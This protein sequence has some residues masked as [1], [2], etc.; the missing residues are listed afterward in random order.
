MRKSTLFIS[1]IL[2]TFMIAVLVGVVSNYQNKDKQES[3]APTQEAPVAVE[4]LPTDTA[5]P[6]PTAA[7]GFITPEQA[8]ALASQIL[9]RND[10]LSVETS[11]LNGEQVYLVKFIPG[12]MVYISPSGQILSIVM[13]PTPTAAVVSAPSSSSNSGGNN[14]V[15]TG[16]GNG[17]GGGGGGDDGG[18]GHD[19]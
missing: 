3:V 11:I 1:A 10:L 18:G 15:Q 19:D 9:G 7:Q 13:V 5:L 8:A 17:G 2:T 12:D 16:R 4:S 14:G 6:E